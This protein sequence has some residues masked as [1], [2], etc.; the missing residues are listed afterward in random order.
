MTDSILIYAPSWVG[1]A[2]MSLGALRVLRKKFTDERMVV[3]TRPS[4]QELYDSCDEVDETILY[5]PMG[6]DKGALGF[7]RAVSRLRKRSFEKCVLFPNAFRA[8]AIVTAAGISERWGYGTE[9]RSFLLTK[10]VPQAPRPFGRHQA[11]FYLDLISQLGIDV[12]GIVPDIHLTPT[13]PMRERAR[14]ILQHE[15]WKGEPLI[16]VH[17]GATNNRAKLWNTSRYAEVAHRIADVSGAKIVVL[18]GPSESSLAKEIS[19]EIPSRLTL[20][21]QGKTS[22]GE[23]MGVLPELAL[24]VTNDSGPMHLA[25][26]LEVPTVAVFG[27]TDPRETGPLS[28][29]ARVV[30]EPVDCSPCAFRDCPIDHRCMERLDTDRVYQEAFTLVSQ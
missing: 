28:K 24:I 23:L 29:V 2:V 5:D 4:V 8:A 26:A 30:R 17:P 11:F 9:S 18:G 21:L 15:G 13:K 10:H 22:L 12:D 7:C 14:K 19:E 16:G 3:L 27:P 6:L 20:M 1:D 25:A